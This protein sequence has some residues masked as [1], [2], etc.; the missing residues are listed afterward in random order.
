MTRIKV[1]M[2]RGMLTASGHAGFGRY[3]KDIVCAAVSALTQTAAAAARKRGGS[4]GVGDGFIEI[5]CED[6]GFKPVLEA[7]ADGLAM[8]AAQYPLHVRLKRR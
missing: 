6:E 5:A 8:I 7:V 2:A 1:D 3:R 4:A